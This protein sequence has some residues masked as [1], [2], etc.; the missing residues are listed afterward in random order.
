MTDHCESPLT[1]SSFSDFKDHD[2]TEDKMDRFIPRKICANLYNLY[3][4][5][6]IESTGKKEPGSNKGSQM[7]SAP[8]SKSKY[9]DLLKTQLLGDDT[10]NFG[11]NANTSIKKNKKK[12][13][14]FA[15]DKKSKK[16]EAQLIK[17]TDISPK[18]QRNLGSQ[19]QRVIAKA[20]TK[21]L[22]APGLL[23]DYY[24]NLMD[25]SSTN[26]IGIGL[27]NHVY[28]WSAANSKVTQ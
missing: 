28:F 15:S 22:D 1:P 3:F 21:V 9:E 7:D 26:L 11:Q 12:M 17:E 27:E 25:W 24:L 14:T 2:I 4:N 5:E 23:D 19:M 6:G 13:I 18:L 16:L 20:P 8:K 10:E